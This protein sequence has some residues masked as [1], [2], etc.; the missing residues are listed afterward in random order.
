MG[1]AIAGEPRHNNANG[2][3]REKEEATAMLTNTYEAMN[4]EGDGRRRDRDGG[5]V[6]VN[7]GE[8][9]PATSGGNRGVDGIRLGA[10]MP[11]TASG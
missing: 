9:F 8:G 5:E 10:A 2:G 7:N 6:R 1:A 4:D 11:T 3:H